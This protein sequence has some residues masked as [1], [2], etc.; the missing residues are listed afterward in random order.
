MKI[1]FFGDVYGKAGRHALLTS[2][3]GL[4]DQFR[5][6]F[7][8]ANGENVAD[9]KGLTEKT[10]KPLILEGVD[11]ITGGNHLWDR[12]EA[13]DYIRTN[14]KIAKPMNYPPS[15]PGNLSVMLSH[16]NNALTVI[17]LSGQIFM[18]GCDNPFLALDQF[19]QTANITHPIILDFHAESTSEK[20]A[21]GWFADGR[22]AAVL[23]THTH[24][25]TA[26]EEIL[27]KGTAYITD[28]GMTG[29]HDSVIG[30]RKQIIIDKLVSGIPARYES[31]YLGLQ[32]NAVLIELDESGMAVGITRIKRFVEDM[33]L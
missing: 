21:M 29:A 27:P 20:R 18:P 23:G 12:A 11:A 28:V 4:K 3:P 8:I 1:L 14:P 10:L 2:L 5:P 31:S 33:V 9:G 7:V 25:Q 6:D 19:L 13:L 17:C 22:I 32:I 30:V 26:D 16:N 24:I 15:T